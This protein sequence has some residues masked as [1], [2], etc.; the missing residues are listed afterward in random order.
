M[1]RCRATCDYIDRVVGLQWTWVLGLDWNTSLWGVPI[2]YFFVVAD[3][4]CGSSGCC[5]RHLCKF[6]RG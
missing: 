2:R 3:L 4:V 6:V 5:S 1:V